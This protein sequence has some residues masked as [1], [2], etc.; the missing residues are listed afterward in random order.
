MSHQRFSNPSSSNEKAMNQEKQQIKAIQSQ[1][2]SNIVV[3]KKES[4]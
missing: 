2:F 1:I 3:Q 4:E